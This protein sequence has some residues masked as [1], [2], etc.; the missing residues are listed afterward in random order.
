VVRDVTVERRMDRMKDE[1]IATASHELRTPLTSILGYLEALREGDAGELAPEQERF[2]EVI[3]RNGDRLRH[4]VDDLLDV[5]R[6]DAGRLALAMAEVDLSE[7]V[8]EASEAARPVAVERG[9]DL[10]VAAPPGA[11]VVGDRR[12][13]GQVVDNLVSNA[14]KFTPPGGSVSV[15]VVADGDAMACEVSDTGVG[16]PEAE[17]ERLFERFYRGSRASA[18]AVQGTGLGL[19]I[20]KMIVE[21]HGGR[22]ALTSEEGRGT[23]VRIT[24]PAAVP[25]PEGSPAGG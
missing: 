5:A 24:L 22:I 20:A 3:A 25:V 7:V 21:S 18:D 11:L 17:Q 4:L 23:R 9:I 6:A 1:F 14:L 8:A 2:L 13:L 19:A 15:T 12:R 16:I 10:S